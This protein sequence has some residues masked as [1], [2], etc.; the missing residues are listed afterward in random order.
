MDAFLP[1]LGQAQYTLP[2]TRTSPVRIVSR[3]RHRTNWKTTNSFH[4]RLCIIGLSYAKYSSQSSRTS[5]GHYHRF[6]QSSSTA[7]ITITIERIGR[8]R[9][10][11][12]STTS[13]TLDDLDNT[14]DRSLH[15]ST[16]STSTSLR[17]KAQSSSTARLNTDQSTIGI[18]R[19]TRTQYRS[20]DKDT[21]S[22]DKDKASSDKDKAKTPIFDRCQLLRIGNK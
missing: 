1:V 14:N 15:S 21:A 18:N 16:R 12:A 19:Q 17:R 10:Y 4:Q 2:R 9:S 6:A 22:S 3:H 5:L 20:S 7:R 8:R 11:T 13:P